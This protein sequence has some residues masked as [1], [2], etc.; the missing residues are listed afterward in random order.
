MPYDDAEDHGEQLRVRRMLEFANAANYVEAALRIS[1]RPSSRRLIALALAALAFAVLLLA[2]YRQPDTATLQIVRDALTSPAGTDSSY[3]M[4]MG[5]DAFHAPGHRI[6]PKL[7]FEDHQKFIYPPSSLF[8]MEAMGLAPRLHFSRETGQLA[9]LL[10][11]WLGTLVAAVW[12]YREQRGSITVLEAGSIVLLAVLFLPIAEAFRRGQAQ[13]G[14]TFLWGLSA[15]LFGRGRRGW[16]GF[17][18]AITCVFKP[19]LVIFLLWG[20]LRKE[21]RFTGAF[22]ATTVLIGLCSLAH[23]GVQNNL[24]YFS[25]LSYLSHH[26]EALW[27]NQSVNGILNRLLHNG[28]PM[29]WNATVYPPYR[30]SIYLICM[31]FSVAG[32]L[33]GLLL[34]Y[35]SGWAATTADFLFFGCM[36]MVIS[37]IVWEH[38]Y[39]YFFFLLVYLFAR[40]ERLSR[41]RWAVLAAS[42]LAMANRLPPLDHRLQ[43]PTSLAGGYLFYAGL[44]VLALLAMEQRNH[45]EPYPR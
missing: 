38:H 17:I 19:Q 26:G 5:L 2:K 24:D 27:A 45:R 37:P 30:A 33:V 43:G 13:L 36:S 25:V 18:L 40:A 6:F 9:L 3:Y 31:T 12:F 28:D 44:A 8:L 42:T 22:A 34:P 29:S 32:I 15:I 4:Q 35:R 7:F 21:W 10:L 11:S 23:F 20:A 16:A 1:S 39:G 14:L 41:L